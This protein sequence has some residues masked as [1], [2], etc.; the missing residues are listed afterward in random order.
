MGAKTI[1]D[2]EN[3]YRLHLRNASL[4]NPQQYKEY[5]DVLAAKAREGFQNLGRGV[6]LVVDDG[7]EGVQ[8][9]IPAE[10]ADMQL[11]VEVAKLAADYEPSHEWILIGLT[12]GR[13][14]P[15]VMPF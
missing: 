1:T 2:G 11:G 10:V 15:I 8:V 12:N 6:L 4:S 5:T 7:N 13:S 9:Y 14:F 3:E